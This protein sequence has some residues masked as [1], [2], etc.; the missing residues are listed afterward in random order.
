MKNE[1]RYKVKTQKCTTTCRH[2]SLRFSKTKSAK[3]RCF[4]SQFQQRNR[5]AAYM[6]HF[7]M[8]QITSLPLHT[9]Q[10]ASF[11]TVN[12][13]RKTLSEALL[14]PQTIAVRETARPGVCTLS[15]LRQCFYFSF[16][17]SKHFQLQNRERLNPFLD[18][19]KTFVLLNFNFPVFYIDDNSCSCSFNFYKSSNCSFLFLQ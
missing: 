13:L 12:I 3:S 14:Q 10:S 18:E 7:V 11:Q 4:N 19:L 9:S 16:P 17:R 5:F 2:S 8:L 6:Q 15:G 1:K